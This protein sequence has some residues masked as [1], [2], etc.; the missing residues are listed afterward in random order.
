MKA[1]NKNKI[2]RR[3]FLK[4][5]GLAAAGVTAASFAVPYIL[6]SGRLFAST[7]G[8]GL[9]DHVV[10]VLF[11]G[12]LRQQETVGQGYLE[13]SQGVNIRGNILYNLL[14]GAP[15]SQKIVYGTNGALSGDT[16]IPAILSQT[17]QQQG[18]LFREMV[19]RQAGHYAGLN[20]LVTGNYE[21]TQGLRNKSNI[22]T[23]FE[24]VRRHLGIPATKA[25]FVGNGI[26]N[27]V[28]LLNYSS[29]ES[30]GAA[31]GA[32]FL[33]PTVTFSADGRTHL[34]DAKVYHPEEELGPMYKMKFFLD[35]AALVEGRDIPG[36]KNTDE[37]K[38][39]LKEFIRLMFQK[40]D[41]NSIAYPSVRDNG[42]LRTI[43][44][45]CEVM[46]YFKPTITVINLNNVDG[47][48]RNFTGYLKSLHRADHGVAHL[49][50]YIQT[51]I[52]EMAG[53]TAIV[54]APECGRNMNPN[55]ILDENNW[56]AFDH[57]DANT[58]RV[59]GMMAGPGIPQNLQIGSEA[60]PVGD[61]TDAVATVGE[62][63]GIKN[64][65]VNSGFLH[66]SAQSWF[67]RI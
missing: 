39:S 8:G 14:D 1:D 32:N 51:Q 2:D 57:S 67:D 66:P 15:P 43:G 40:G 55:P 38:N 52:P 21:Y 30:Y 4:K 5:M 61:V 59:F 44:Y 33:A 22:P 54:L 60:N 16:P 10:F 64:E 37:E 3:K 63:L 47:C 26:G 31:Y 65:I 45:A 11:A 17:M 42:D 41:A 62:I 50:D 13:D 12:G 19:S 36:I 6:P 56:F 48:H 46:K 28:P 34:A 23:I 58:Q 27:S 7:G 9:A 29:H 49:W 25:W 35:Q 53:N 18:V 24:Y 20:A